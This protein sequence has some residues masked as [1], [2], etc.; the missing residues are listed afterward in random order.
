MNIVDQ[1]VELYNG[2]TAHRLYDEVV[3]EREHALQCAALA[4]RD[5]AEREVVVAALLHDVGHLLLDDNVTLDAPLTVDHGHDA[6][7]ARYLARWFASSV[8]APIALHVS[9][10]RYL[11]AREPEYL[12]VLSPSS[13]RSLE[14]QGGP[15]SSAE[16]ARFERRP[17]SAQAISLRRW[18]D[19]GKIDGLEVP[20]FDDYAPMLHDLATKLT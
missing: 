16:V 4:V 13:L 20:D 9:A 6:A 8:T 10:K 19:M 17:A 1:L 7:G 5:G 11:C 2:S 3:T 12:A 15:M 18:D 14:V